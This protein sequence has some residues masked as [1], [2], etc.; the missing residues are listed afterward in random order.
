M[1]R[2]LLAVVLLLSGARQLGAAEGQPCSEGEKWRQRPGNDDLFVVIDA[3]LSMGPTSFGPWALGYFDPVRQ[4]LHQLAACYLKAGD[5]VLVGTF[6]SEARIEIAQEIRLPERDLATLHAQLDALGPSRPRYWRRSSDGTRGAEVALAIPGQDLVLGGS[7]RTDLGSGLTLAKESLERYRQPG[8]R[9]LLLLFT[10]GR[11]EAPEYSPYYRKAVSLEDFFP[12]AGV[13]R[14]RLGLVAMPGQDGQVDP[15]IAALAAKWGAESKGR[16]ALLPIAGE[17][18]E[19]KLGEEILELLTK[20]IDLVRPR[21]PLD[22]GRQV[23]P[24][25][26]HEFAVKNLSGVKERISLGQIRF[27]L[28][29]GDTVSVLTV[30][31]TVLI[32]GPQETVS[33][34]VRGDL[35]GVAS[36]KFNGTLRIDFAEATTFEPS[37]LW[38]K[39]ERVAWLEAHWRLVLCAFLAAAAVAGLGVYWWRRPVWALMSWSRGTSIELSQPRPLRVGRALR[40]G[41]DAGGGLYVQGPGKILG[42]VARPRRREYRIAFGEHVSSREGVEGWEVLGEALANEVPEDRSQRVCFYFRGSRSAA[43][44]LRRSLGG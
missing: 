43:A 23:T 38:V 30:D 18:G 41:T 34:Q 7:L 17:A 37:V 4:A 15:L 33:F 28:G 21:D 22:L 16:V 14:H 39:G 1:R 8:H 42:A 31:P 20:R 10:D 13:G 27:E 29:G 9:Q 25:I 5:F 6:D 2:V 12:N 40:F 11:H 24:R 36:G 32:L 44:S 26:D 19:A 3:S 35:E